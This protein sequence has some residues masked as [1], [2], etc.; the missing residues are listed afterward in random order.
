MMKREAFNEI[1]TQWDRRYA[2]HGWSRVPE[3][4]L[5]ELA[6]NLEPGL[7]LDLGCGTGR[8]S[9]WLARMGWEVTGVDASQVGISMMEEQVGNE[10]LKIHG[11]L[12]DLRTYEPLAEGFDLVVLANVH[13]DPA[14]RSQLFQKAIA[15]LAPGGHLYL[16]GHHI[17]ALG[18]SGPPFLD[19]LYDESILKSAF[20]PLAIDL[21]EKR[22]SESDADGKPE[23][24]MLLW[25]MKPNTSEGSRQ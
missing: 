23:S 11:V 18:R 15:A 7:A 17:S 19:R 22:T 25:A 12:S 6:G 8:N 4:S 5:L 3:A 9:L 16:V 1:G 2:D 14:E 10:L 13:L 20:Q 21:L 24:V